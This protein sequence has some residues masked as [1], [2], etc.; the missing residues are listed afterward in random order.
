MT[1][2]T[3]RVVVVDDS[4]AFRAAAQDVVEATPGFEL[5]GAA[6]SV[7]GAVATA[8][9]VQPDLVLMDVRMPGVGGV[10]AARLIRETRQSTVVVLI[11]ASGEASS[12]GSS[13]EAV[14]KWS[15]SPSALQ[16]L[17]ESR[18][19]LTQRG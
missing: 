19:C 14:D 3:V 9:R 13:S 10:E 1:P 16:L 6:E 5:V 8:E 12:G 11:T 15:L 7:E 17:W 18:G 2:A 4:A